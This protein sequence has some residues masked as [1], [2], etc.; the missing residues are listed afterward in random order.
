MY[1]KINDSTFSR[2]KKR[3]RKPMDPE[4]KK[5]L[6]KERLQAKKDEKIK[7][8]SEKKKARED[9]KAAAQRWIYISNFDRNH[10]WNLFQF[11]HN[12]FLFLRLSSFCEV[13]SFF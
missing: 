10:S 3:G 7:I 4:L 9:K 1:S 5:K 2:P 12:S 11:F 13:R 6:Q 8:K